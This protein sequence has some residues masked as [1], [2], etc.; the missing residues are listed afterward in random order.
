MNQH[1]SALG[2]SV[3]NYCAGLGSDPL[4]VQGAGGNVSWKDG[5]TLWVKA[6]GAWLA[7]AASRDVFVPVDLVDLRASIAK[8]EFSA[9]PRLQAVSE[10]RPS[11]ETLLH[12]LM[13]QAVVVHLHA[14]EV[15][16]R[17]VRA[18]LQQELIARIGDALDW[19]CVDYH[20]PGADLAEAIY[21]ALTAHS[22]AN[23]VFMK[24]HGLVVGG[25]NVDE[26][27]RRLQKI[28][29]L[30]R[31]TS[32]YVPSPQAAFSG[33]DDYVALPDEALQALAQDGLLFQRLATDWAICPDHVVF[34][35]PAAQTYESWSA[36]I[37]TLPT[38]ILKPELVFIQHCG[39]FVTPGFSQAKAAQLRCY[40]DVLVRQ[41]PGAVLDSLSH[42][43]IAQVLNWDSEKYRQGLEK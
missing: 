10:L 12:A 13:P 15:L 33:H 18:T 25:A 29:A 6:S 20:K 39:V 3:K 30:L 27:R 35:G 21:T 36:F 28:I 14:V 16:A 32:V 1:C 11:I 34:L 4:M 41:P 19:V 7:D 17:L 40:Y 43:Q 38:L 37:S 9:G 8:G 42:L 26:V 22:D 23:V 2:N 5:N 24:N 31:E